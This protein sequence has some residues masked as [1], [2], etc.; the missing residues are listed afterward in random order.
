[1]SLQ[2]GFVSTTAPTHCGL[3]TFNDS[4][5]RELAERG[6]DHGQIIRV[7]DTPYPETR[8]EVITQFVPGDVASTERAADALNNLDVAIVQHEFGIYGNNDGEGVLD[9]LQQLRIPTIVVVHTVPA[10]P[11]PNQRRVLEDVVGLADA[12]ITMTRSASDRLK[13]CF[14]VRSTPVHVIPH[15]TAMQRR[16]P[17][18]ALNIER[19]TVLT[20][21]LIG[22]GKGIEWGLEAMALLKELTPQPRYIVAGGTHPRVLMRDGEAY[23]EALQARAAELGLTDVVEFDNQYRDAA[24]LADLVDSADVVLLPYDS[25]DQ[26]TSGVLVEAV[27]A[28][29]PVVATPF[30]HAVEVLSRGSGALVKHRDSHDMAAALREIITNQEVARQMRNAAAGLRWDFLWP[31]VAGRYRALARQLVR[32]RVA[33]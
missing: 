23:R 20:W 30:P 13:G 1:M 26:V 8:D 24:S 15:G 2:F 19:P 32:K 5:F 21:G 11:S 14:D 12:A 29:K 10:D 7:V 31:N 3:A 9:L 33:A 28:L 22:P 25:T 6:E 4:L 16:R 27:S 17:T 18:K